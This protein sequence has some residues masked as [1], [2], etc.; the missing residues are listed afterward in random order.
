MYS[1][2]KLEIFKTAYFH[3]AQLRTLCILTLKKKGINRLKKY[4][5]FRRANHIHHDIKKKTLL[6]NIIN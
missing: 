4:P 2:E 1:F 5:Y 6:S 3:W